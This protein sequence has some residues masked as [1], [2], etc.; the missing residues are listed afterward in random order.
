L[1][2]EAK[3][4]IFRRTYGKYFLYLPERPATVETT[5]TTHTTFEPT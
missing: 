2:A 5:V 1:V 4:S 3:G